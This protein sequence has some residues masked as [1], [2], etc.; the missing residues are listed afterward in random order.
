MRVTITFAMLVLAA[1]VGFLT[2]AVAQP[3]L[4]PAP[5]TPVYPA[6]QQ[7][8]VA[9]RPNGPYGPVAAPGTSGLYNVLNYGRNGARCTPSPLV[10][11]ACR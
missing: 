6:P 3:S 5:A 4:P 7:P 11:T 2:V 8:P 1:M 9:T 10:P